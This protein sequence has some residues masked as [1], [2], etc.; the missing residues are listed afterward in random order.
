MCWMVFKQWFFKPFK[1]PN[2]Y[3][4]WS[5]KK[6]FT[7][8]HIKHNTYKFFDK[9]IQRTFKGSKEKYDLPY[10]SEGHFPVE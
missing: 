7:T 9:K 6:K 4:R 5:L 10:C 3:P 8:L 2:F 1:Q